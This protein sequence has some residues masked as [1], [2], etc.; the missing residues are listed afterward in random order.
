MSDSDKPDTQALI[1]KQL[2]SIKIALC[3][4]VVIMLLLSGVIV[5]GGVV[6]GIAAFSGGA[7]YDYA[8]PEIKTSAPGPRMG[9]V[10]LKD[11][12]A[13]QPPPEYPESVQTRHSG[14]GR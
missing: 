5:V 14:S 12:P 3:L 11:H 13:N 7:H 10:T 9:E 1:L 2:K 8:E 4:V 6:A